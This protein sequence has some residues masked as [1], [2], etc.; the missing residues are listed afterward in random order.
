MGVNASTFAL[1]AEFSRRYQAEAPSL[2]L[3]RQK[4]QPSKCSSRMRVQRSLRRYRPDLQIEDLLQAD[5]YAESMFEALGFPGIETLDASDWEFPD[6]GNVIV[7]DLNAPVP[8]ELHDRYNFIYD[9]GTLE[10]VFNVPTALKNMFLMLKPGGR[11]I[12]VNPLNGLPGHGM[13]QFTAELVYGF[14]GRI[15]KCRINKICAYSANWGMY[16]QE[17]ADPAEVGRRTRYRSMLFPFSRIPP[18]RIYLFYE[19]EKVTGASLD[20]AA[21]QPDY[22]VKW[23][24]ASQKNSN[25]SRQTELPTENSTEGGMRPGPKTSEA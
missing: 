14:W 7:H 20:G 4:F 10:H 9:G 8:E 12:G 21:L 6:G 15:A 1:L 5:C 19:I 13:Y 2:M 11:A 16:H 25:S 18:G 22:V 17:I 24:A 3:G 23:D